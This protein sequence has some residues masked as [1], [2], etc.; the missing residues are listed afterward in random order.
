MVSFRAS[1]ATVIK[2]RRDPKYHTLPV[3]ILTDEQKKDLQFVGK[4]TS[5]KAWLAKPFKEKQFLFII[6]K[7]LTAA[8]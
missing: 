7:F 4:V 2:L 3:V 1:M 6:N 8:T 5:A